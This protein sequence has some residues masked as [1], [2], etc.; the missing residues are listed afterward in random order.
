MEDAYR[1]ST[2]E[3]D[4]EAFTEIANVHRVKKV[5][6][7]QSAWSRILE[8]LREMRTYRGMLGNQS[9]PSASDWRCS[10]TKSSV[11]RQPMASKCR[12][13]WTAMISL[14]VHT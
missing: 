6:L 8:L 12:D 14:Q 3:N 9:G 13:A 2:R 1:R 10:Q 11:L 7:L 5:E 4:A